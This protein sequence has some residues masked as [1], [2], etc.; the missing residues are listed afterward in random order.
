MGYREAGDV[1]LDVLRERLGSLHEEIAWLEAQPQGVMKRLFG[2]RAFSESVELGFEVS[3]E[4]LQEVA[5]ATFGVVGRIRRSP[6]GWKWMGSVGRR[7]ITLTAAAKG[8]FFSERLRRS[9]GS[10]VGFVAGGFAA[11]ILA[12]S[13]PA[14][15]MLVLGIPLLAFLALERPG[16]LRIARRRARQFRDLVRLL[17]APRARVSTE[18]F[19]LVEESALDTSVGGRL[20]QVE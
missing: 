2:S 10:S 14:L 1:R 18:A 6:D 12:T 11:A 16:R 8:L 19:D 5:D 15:A 9:P 17:R 20:E 7:D 3:A 4:R 13:S